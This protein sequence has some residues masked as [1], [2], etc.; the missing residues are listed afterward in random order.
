MLDRHVDFS[1]FGGKGPHLVVDIG[2]GVKQGVSELLQAVYT[3]PYGIY[4]SFGA[5]LKI[6]F[7]FPNLGE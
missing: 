7:G 3:K 4:C 5:G 6:N 2:A 1:K